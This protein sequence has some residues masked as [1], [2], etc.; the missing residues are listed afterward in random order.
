[1]IP[2]I[3]YE[4]SAAVCEPVSQMEDQIGEIFDPG[5]QTTLDNK[6]AKSQASGR[7]FDQKLSRIL[8]ALVLVIA[9]MF[10]V[11]VYFQG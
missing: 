4:L 1:M 9:L 2:Y 6:R 3:G 10:L 11:V 7:R 5:S 8:L